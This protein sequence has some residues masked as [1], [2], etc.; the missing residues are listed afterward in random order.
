[1]RE[2]GKR[3]LLGSSEPLPHG[4]AGVGWEGAGPLHLEAFKAGAEMEAGWVLLGIV[5]RFWR[6]VI[7]YTSQTAPLGELQETQP[8]ASCCCCC[9]VRSAGDKRPGLL[10]ARPLLSLDGKL[11]R[12]DKRE[13]QGCSF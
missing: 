7:F 8:L 6:P 12:E 11:L 3:A 1:M 2:P 13:E 9:V 10:E 4:G 5:P